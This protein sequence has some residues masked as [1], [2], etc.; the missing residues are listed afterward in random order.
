[1]IRYLPSSTRGLLFFEPAFRLGS[2]GDA[3]WRA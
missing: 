2:E 1:M 3:L